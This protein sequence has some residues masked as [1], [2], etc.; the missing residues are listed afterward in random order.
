M[1]LPSTHA[2]STSLRQTSASEAGGA[3]L[4]RPASPLY[5][6]SL[7]TKEE[8]R[9]PNHRELHPDPDEVDAVRV[10]SLPFAGEESGQSLLCSRRP[11][12]R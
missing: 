8:G 11:L 12:A 6:V 9:G 10:G 1:P 5:L 3:F 2:A 4:W 7:R